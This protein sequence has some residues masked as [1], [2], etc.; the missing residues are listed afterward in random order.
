MPW[1]QLRIHSSSE[2][3]ETLSDLL[4]EEGS[5]SITFE[6]GK[7]TPILSPNWEKPHFGPTLWWS[8]CSMPAQI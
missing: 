8:L 5:V 4:L 6:D 3:A 2:H 7:D 1:I